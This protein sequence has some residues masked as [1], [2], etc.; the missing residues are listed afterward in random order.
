MAKLARSVG[1][2]D[3]DRLYYELSPYELSVHLALF[4]IEPWGDDRADLR[5][6]LNTIK[7]VAA[8]TGESDDNVL[9]EVFEGTARYLA[10]SKPP[11]KILSPSEIADLASS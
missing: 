4:E 3:F 11:E 7:Q 6:A 2:L 10:V 8:F 1:R 5:A 9:Q